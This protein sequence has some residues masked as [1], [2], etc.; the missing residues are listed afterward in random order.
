MIEGNGVEV[1]DKR[2]LRASRCQFVVSCCI[3]DNTVLKVQG[4]SGVAE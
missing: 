3:Q 1:G 2:L 4:Q